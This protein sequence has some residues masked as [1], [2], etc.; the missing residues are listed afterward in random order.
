MKFDIIIYTLRLNTHGLVP[1][2]HYQELFKIDSSVLIVILNLIL[3][4]ILKHI[5]IQ[6]KRG[7]VNVL[8]CKFILTSCLLFLIFLPGIKFC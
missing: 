1:L 6:E 8:V 4:C 3:D 2:I 7:V 5:V